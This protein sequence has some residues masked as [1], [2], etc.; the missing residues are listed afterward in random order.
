MT[1]GFKINGQTCC[2]LA[3]WS[4]TGVGCH[5]GCPGGCQSL[6][7]YNLCDGVLRSCVICLF[8]WVRWALF[9]CMAIRILAVITAAMLWP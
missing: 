8:F 9:I 2:T 5:G 3:A 4:V 7:V 1:P 6:V